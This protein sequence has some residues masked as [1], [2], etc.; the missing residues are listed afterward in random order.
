MARMHM[1]QSKADPCVFFKKDD[2]GKTILIAIC[3]VDDNL[4]FRLKS[5]IQWYKDKVKERFE[6][7]DLGPLKKHLG[8]W[9][10]LKYDENGNRYLEATM[11]K[12]VREIIELYEKHTKGEAKIYLLPAT[13]GLCMEKWTGEPLEQ[14]MYRKIVGKIM[15]CVTKIF[16]EASNAARELARHFSSPGPQQLTELAK[17]VGYLKGIEEDIKLIYRKPV[18]LRALS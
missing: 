10:K 2:K 16:P 5:E 9:Y 6:Y 18:E 7:K 3:F 13:A 15:F 17:F 14:T 12:K 8:V 4:L 1:E 11:P